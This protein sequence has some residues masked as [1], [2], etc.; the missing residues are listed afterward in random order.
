M[1]LIKKKWQQSKQ[2]KSATLIGLID[3]TIGKES[4][5]LRAVLLY[6]SNYNQDHLY[7]CNVAIMQHEHQQKMSYHLPKYIAE[8]SQRKESGLVRWNQNQ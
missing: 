3:L 7:Q 2:K 4:M 6:C 1:T 8:A 5:L